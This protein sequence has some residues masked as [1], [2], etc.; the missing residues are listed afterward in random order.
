MESL[1]TRAG[2]LET[3]RELRQ[4]LESVVAEAGEERMEQPGSFGEL[5]FKDVIAHLTSWR[6][7]TAARLEAGLSG[8]EPVFPWP[9]HLEEG[10][11][12]DEIN[13]WFFETNHDKP[14]ADVLADSRETFERV[15]RAISA[16]PEDDLFVQDRFP[17]LQGYTLGPGVV[18]GTF[19]HYRV[20]HEPEIRAWLARG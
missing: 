1:N 2:L 16:L 11:D 9:A 18:R 6:L 3:V 12:T 13:R 8:A 4:D 17:W 19:E 5:T 7:T 14:L 15:A 20:D 10:K